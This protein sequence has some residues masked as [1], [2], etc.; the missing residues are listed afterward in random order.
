MNGGP[1]GSRGSEP[2]RSAGGCTYWSLNVTGS[3]IRTRTGRP[4]WRP[5]VNRL[6]RTASTAA[7]SHPPADAADHLHVAHRAVLV[8]DEA[9]EDAALDPDAPREL[10][11]HDPLLQ[12]RDPAHERGHHLRDLDERLLI[13]GRG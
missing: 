6:W 4:R 10:G 7:S 12:P 8:H 13:V 9:D 11:V 3:A 1:A 5:G 2:R